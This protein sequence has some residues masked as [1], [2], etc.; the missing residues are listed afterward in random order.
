MM[1]SFDGHM[2][3]AELQ[4]R[5]G[6]Q[7]FQFASSYAVAEY[8]NAR[9]RFWNR[10]VEPED[11]LLPSIIGALYREPTRSELMRVGQFTYEV[12][13]RPLWQSVAF[14]VARRLR[15]ATAQ[16][17]PY[18][19]YWDRVG[20][21]RP[22]VFDLDLPVVIKGHLQSPRYFM[23]IEDKIL[24]ALRLP[25]YPDLSGYGK[26]VGVSFRRGDY[27]SLNLALPLKYYDDAL[28]VVS[29]AVPGVTYVLFG[30]DT[31]F[32]ELIRERLSRRG[33]VINGLQFGAQPLQQLVAMAACDHSVIANSSFAWWGAWLGDRRPTGSDRIVVAPEEYGIPDRLPA[34]WITV[35]AGIAPG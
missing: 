8:H 10:V 13:P 29:S 7:L 24:G 31:A 22:E 20:S 32:L 12:P 11:L 28:D 1:N 35:P 19:N 25:P 30:D 2:V 27:N 17:P 3:I 14:R 5:L 18:V 16:T 21:Y 23:D 15:Q 26:V 4:G 34:E 9:L 6:N 33:E